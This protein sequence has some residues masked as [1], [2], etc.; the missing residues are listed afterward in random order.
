MVDHSFSR[1]LLRDNL[2]EGDLY[3]R[4]YDIPLIFPL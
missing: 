3:I 1:V 2:L 4:I